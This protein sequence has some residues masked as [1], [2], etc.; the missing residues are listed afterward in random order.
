VIDKRVAPAAP[1]HSIPKGH[2]LTPEERAYVVE[3]IWAWIE[4]ELAPARIPA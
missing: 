1:W 2:E 4:R 3:V